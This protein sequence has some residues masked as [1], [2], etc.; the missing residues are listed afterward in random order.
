MANQTGFFSEFALVNVSNGVWGINGLSVADDGHQM[1]VRTLTSS[2]SV[3]EYGFELGRSD[4]VGGSAYY[5]G[6][7][8]NQVSRDF[9]IKL[10]GVDLSAL[11][12]GAPVNGVSLVVEQKLDILLP[13][14]GVTLAGSVLL[15]HVFD[16]SGMTIHHEQ[17]YL[18]GFALFGPDGSFSAMLPTTGAMDGGINMIQM[19]TIRP[20]RSLIR[21]QIM[22]SAPR[23]RWRAPGTPTTIT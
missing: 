20:D 23:R 15:D 3:W 7:H 2:N 10:D 11:P 19:G 5:G 14:D 4:E 12:L 6:G 8:G 1:P 9:D 22:T 21:A 16:Q 18:D 13:A 17:D